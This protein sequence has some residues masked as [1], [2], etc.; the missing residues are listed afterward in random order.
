MK[1]LWTEWSIIAQF[2]GKNEAHV[3]S[4][5]FCIEYLRQSSCQVWAIFSSKSRV[6]LTLGQNMVYG[7]NRVIRKVIGSFGVRYFKDSLY[8]VSL[9]VTG[10][11]PKF[12][13]I[14]YP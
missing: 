13:K 11:Y 9:S 12:A 2:W 10:K 3:L 14:P 4:V 5:T 1:I 7:Y 8:A 6:T